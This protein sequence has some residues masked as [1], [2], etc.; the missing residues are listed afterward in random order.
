LDTL[1][2]WQYHPADRRRWEWPI[3]GPEAPFSFPHVADVHFVV[4][5]W[6][7][8]TEPRQEAERR[9]LAELQKQVRDYLTGAEAIAKDQYRLVKSPI[10]MQAEHFT[11]FV[12]YQVLGESLASI[13]TPAR[14][15]PPTVQRAIDSIGQLLSG[16]HWRAWK[17]PRGKSGPR[18]TR[19]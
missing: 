10:K 18:S 4:K 9:I 3:R 1:L 19:S 11:W 15:D 17:R 7:P 13:A 5:G 8:Q 6:H 16:P 12:R 2:H 14:T